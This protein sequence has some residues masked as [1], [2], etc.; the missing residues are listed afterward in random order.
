MK[1]LLN[2][3]NNILE[4]AKTNGLKFDLKEHDAVKAYHSAVNDYVDVKLFEGETLEA[5]TQ[6]DDAISYIDLK[7]IIKNN[8]HNIKFKTVEL[9]CYQKVV[10]E[11][12]V[13]E[14]NRDFSGKECKQT[15]IEY[16]YEH[17]YDTNDKDKSA[18]VFLREAPKS[19]YTYVLDRINRK[20]YLVYL[21]SEVEKLAQKKELLSERKYQEYCKLLEKDAEEKAKV[22]H[23]QESY[24]KYNRDVYERQSEAHNYYV[25]A[26]QLK[27]ML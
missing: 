15:L 8:P 22:L 9:L 3:K 7:M 25:D 12:V 11:K 13:K 17:Y 4:W 20:A 23:A 5:L 18:S 1:F 14:I 19:A 26:I 16:T 21:V 10:G 2:Q 6:E 27:N 24:K